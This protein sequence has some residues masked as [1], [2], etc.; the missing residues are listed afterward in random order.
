MKGGLSGVHLKGK[1]FR[2]SCFLRTKLNKGQTLKDKG[3]FSPLKK[4]VD[5]H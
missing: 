3:V 1:C 4:G 2:E 5:S